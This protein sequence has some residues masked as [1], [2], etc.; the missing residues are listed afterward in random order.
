MYHHIQMT[1]YGFGLTE[2]A[3]D[4]RFTGDVSLNGDRFTTPSDNVL[5]R[6][7]SWAL[8]PPA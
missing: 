6:F 8:V 2:K 4:I 7:L 3:A 1:G 5:N